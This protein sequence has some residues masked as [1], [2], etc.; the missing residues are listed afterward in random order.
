MKKIAGDEGY[1][2]SV[3]VLVPGVGEVVG[4]S[5][6]IDDKDELL[7]AFQRNGLP[8]EPYYWYLDQNK[9]GAAPRGGYGLGVERIIAW[10]CAQYTV[11][12]CCLYPRYTGRCTP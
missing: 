9:Y 5:M 8:I 12:S 6:R 11:R 4:A 10:I 2:E 1:T 7:E 3:D